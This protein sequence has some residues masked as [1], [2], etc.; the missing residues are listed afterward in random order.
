M[1]EPALP[2]KVGLPNPL[3]ESCLYTYNCILDA[4]VSHLTMFPLD[5]A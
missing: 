3:L 2:S 4:T 5:T 1:S